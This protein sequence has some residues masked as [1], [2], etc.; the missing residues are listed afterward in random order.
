[1]AAPTSTSANPA[2][3]LPAPL[4]LAAAVLVAPAAPLPAAVDAAAGVPLTTLPAAF[5]LRATNEAE[6]AV[7]E[8]AV[9]RAPKR[10][11]DL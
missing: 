2:P 5:V 11:A 1:M 7:A 9:R 8:E 4:A 6:V 3:I 10:S